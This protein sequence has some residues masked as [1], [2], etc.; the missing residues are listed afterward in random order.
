VTGVQTCALPVFHYFYLFI[1]FH[2]FEGPT[3][4]AKIVLY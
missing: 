1:Y 4:P 2:L 3:A